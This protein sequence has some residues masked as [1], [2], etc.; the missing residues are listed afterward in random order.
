VCVFFEAYTYI[1]LFGQSNCSWFG[2]FLCDQPIDSMG[3]IFS[4]VPISEMHD[5]NV[6]WDAFVS[7]VGMFYVLYKHP[8]PLIALPPV[9]WW[10]GWYCV[11]HKWGLHFSWYYHYQFHLNK[12]RII[13]FF[14]NAYKD[15]NLSEDQAI[16]QPNNLGMC[17]SLLSQWYLG[18]YFD[19]S[20]SFFI[21]LL[22]WHGLPRT[23][24]AFF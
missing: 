23:L 4:N 19:R 12:F 7:I 11:H 8:C 5:Y 6:I 1:K 18:V 14:K 21:V 9:F 17:L 13:P 2:M 3:Y 10:V 15:C 20:T 16:S 24:N 22:T